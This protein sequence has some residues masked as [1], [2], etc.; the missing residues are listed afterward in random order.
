MA[1][2][3]RTFRTEDLYAI[4]V[5]DR[6]ASGM[7]RGALLE[8]LFALGTGM[9]LEREGRIAGYACVRRWGRG[10]VIGPVVAQDAAQAKALIAR[11]AA[12]HVGEFVRI[13]VTRGDLSQWLEEIGLPRVD[14][15]VSMVRGDPPV[16]A[17]D[18]TLYAL[19][20]QSL[21]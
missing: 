6:R 17:P 1:E 9:V 10:I 7:G 21:G 14:L 2:R 4:R 3:I 15:V 18:A 8:A 16:R 11:L 5:L 20:N 19:S 12:A 13:D